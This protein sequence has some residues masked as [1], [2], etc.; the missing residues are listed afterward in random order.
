MGKKFFFILLIIAAASLLL[1]YT[2]LQPLKT[3][4]KVEIKKGASGL[5]DYTIIYKGSAKIGF[6]DARP[7]KTDT[8]ILLCIPGA[9]TRLNDYKIDGLFI[10]NG[11][12]INKDKINHSLGGGIKIEDG[13]CKIFSTQYGKL[14]T[15]SLINAIALKKGSFFQQIRMLDDDGP[16]HFID[17]TITWRRGIT[18]FKNGDIAIIESSEPVAL[19]TF[20]RDIY[21]LGAKSLIYTDM[22]AWDE[23]WYRNA[24]GAPIRIGKS[25]TQTKLQSNWVVF[26][27]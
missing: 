17:S 3:P 12:V 14:L 20:A 7:L 16:A 11:Q 2:L 21:A 9:F 18:I 1:H 13:A 4:L 5:S 15:D 8:S 25:L 27:R 23:G 10:C 19:A 6:E 24:D 22:G 26:R